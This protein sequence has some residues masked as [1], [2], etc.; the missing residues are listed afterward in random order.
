MRICAKTAGTSFFSARR[1]ITAG[2]AGE[3]RAD[4]LWLMALVLI[5]RVKNFILTGIARSGV[6]AQSLATNDTFL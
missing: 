4:M 1:A 5:A 3:M 6:Y 2:A